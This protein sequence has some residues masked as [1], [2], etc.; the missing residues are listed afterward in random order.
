MYLDFCSLASTGLMKNSVKWVC[1][2]SLL[3]FGAGGAKASSRF[4]AMKNAN[5]SKAGK[6]SRV[7]SRG[8]KTFTVT[9]TTYWAQGA[10]SD[11]WTRKKI[12]STGQKL[13]PGVSVAAD[14]RVIPYGSIIDIKGVGRRVVKDTGAHVV[15]RVAS[16]RRGVNYPVID[17]FFERR[18]DAL[19]FARSNPA[20][21][22]VK[23]VK[24]GG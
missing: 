11:Y 1:L 21:A 18:E 24:L 19:R 9:L 13:V 12:S 22:E 6:S 17:L 2:V 16:Q 7:S 5:L 3:L 10:G 8:G 14:P 20:F 15:R 4:E 23:V